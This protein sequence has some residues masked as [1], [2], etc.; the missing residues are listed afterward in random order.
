MATPLE[1]AYG[2]TDELLAAVERLRSMGY[3]INRLE[4]GD[5][6]L[7]TGHGTDRRSE[8]LTKREIIEFAA[9]ATTCTN[10]EC[11]TNACPEH[12][13]HDGGDHTFE[14]HHDSTDHVG[15]GS[16][17]CPGYIVEGASS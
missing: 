16:C 17:Q 5:F 12:R 9:I 7:G 3:R 1:Q 15:P 10:E 4:N 6:V 2:W 11:L 13:A 8:R 14:Q